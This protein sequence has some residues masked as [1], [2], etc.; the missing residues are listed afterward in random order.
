MGSYREREEV[1]GSCRRGGT[2]VAKTVAGARYTGSH[3]TNI[4][5]D[6]GS[7]YI[8]S[9]DIDIFRLIPVCQPW[10]RLT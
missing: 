5:S 9:V 10:E 3:M 8:G 7:V 4:H 6:I 2:K 1:E